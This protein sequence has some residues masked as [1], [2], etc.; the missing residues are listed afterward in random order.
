MQ[1]NNTALEL[2]L[3]A[4]PGDMVVIERSLDL[5]FHVFVLK[6]FDLCTQNFLSS[7]RALSLTWKLHSLSIDFLVGIEVFVQN[8]GGIL[9]KLY[10]IFMDNE[11]ILEAYVK[12]RFLMPLT[13]PRFEDHLHIV[14]VHHL[15]SFIFHT[16]TVD[17][18]L[19]RNRLVRSLFERLCW[20][21]TT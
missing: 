21:T 17:K 4:G 3:M 6:Y 9:L 7:R 1:R 15:P 16:C 10:R 20:E 13:G 2:C 19:L 8:E 5:L 12:S 18:L 14:V 11:D